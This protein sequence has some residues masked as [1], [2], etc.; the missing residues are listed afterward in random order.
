MLAVDKF[1]AFKFEA[2]LWLDAIWFT[3][4]HGPNPEM[5]VELAAAHRVPKWMVTVYLYL[6][7]LGSVD[8]T[9]HF[10]RGLRTSS[11]DEPYLE[12]GGLLF[13]MVKKLQTNL[14]ILWNSSTYSRLWYEAHKSEFDGVSPLFSIFDLLYK[15]REIYV[16]FLRVTRM[17]G[18]IN[19]KQ[20]ADWL[21]VCERLDQEAEAFTFHGKVYFQG[22]VTECWQKQQA[23]QLTVEQFKRICEGLLNETVQEV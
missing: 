16:D 4:S 18:D 1:L 5:V 2:K 22:V 14:P 6:R 7:K 12:G 9:Y 21:P 8:T 11:S 10:L 19:D 3:V 17:L 23:G 15:R 20:Y 13:Q